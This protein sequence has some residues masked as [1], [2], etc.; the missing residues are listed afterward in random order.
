MRRNS[1]RMAREQAAARARGAMPKA[2]ALKAS[3]ARWNSLFLCALFVAIALALLA[4]K[5]GWSSWARS[6]NRRR[7]KRSM[8]SNRL[9]DRRTDSME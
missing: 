3:S 9:D 1:P 5:D 6:V 4:P 2:Q 7:K 8:Y